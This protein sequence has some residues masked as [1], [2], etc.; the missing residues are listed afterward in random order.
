MDTFGGGPLRVTLRRY[1]PTV[2]VLLAGEADHQAVHT[3]GEVRA[4]LPR[5]VAVVAC[6][7]QNVSFMDVSGLRG[8]IDLHRYG[9]RHG[10]TVLIYN[11]QRQPLQLLHLTLNHLD[12]HDDDLRGLSEI[13][14]EHT[15]AQLALGIDAAHGDYAPA[16]APGPPPPAR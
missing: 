11:W 9:R 1:G 12:G 2:H 4:R 3:L 15:E 6:D 7:L 10:A 16:D 14:T 13:L 8:L 5:D